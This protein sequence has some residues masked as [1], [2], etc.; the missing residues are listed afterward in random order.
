VVASAGEAGAPAEPRGGRTSRGGSVSSAGQG[1][2]E[3]VTGD[4]GGAAG[5]EYAGGSGAGGD[6]GGSVSDDGGSGGQPDVP[7]AGNPCDPPPVSAT[8]VSSYDCAGLCGEA[9]ESY[10]CECGGQALNA[11]EDVSVAQTFQLGPDFAMCTEVG[12]VGA[13]F[14]FGTIAPGACARLTAMD[15]EVLLGA[16]SSALSTGCAIVEGGSSA[17]ATN[18]QWPTWVRLEFSRTPC[19]YTCP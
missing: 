10:V 12:Q 14:A 19:A 9:N 4:Q 5:Q 17:M 13:T 2:D 15:P 6:S 7:P 8:Y 1:G 18:I 16:A 11:G 3:P